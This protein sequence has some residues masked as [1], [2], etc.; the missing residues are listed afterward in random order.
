MKN[1]KRYRDLGVGGWGGKKG[2]VTEYF[3]HNTRVPSASL[4]SRIL[5]EGI[6]VLDRTSSYS[7]V[8]G[9]ENEGEGGKKGEK[10]KKEKGNRI[11]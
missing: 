3:S 6:I 8:K 10:E 5:R 2:V 9:K 4:R 1:H 11:K 7:R